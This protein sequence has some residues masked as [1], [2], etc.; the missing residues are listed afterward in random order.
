M[1]DLNLLHKRIQAVDPLPCG[2]AFAVLEGPAKL[3]D[4]AVKEVKGDKNTGTLEHV[5][6]LIAQYQPDIV[7]VEDYANSRRYPRVK[8]LI[9]AIIKL[10]ARSHINTRRISQRAVKTTFSKL[11]RPTKYEIAIAIAEQFPELAPRLPRMRKPWMSEDDRM[12]IFDAVALALTFYV[13]K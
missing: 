8:Q 11:R 10:A 12:S 6:L 2:V 7:V 1:S 5:A 3:I 4:W 9:Q 13:G